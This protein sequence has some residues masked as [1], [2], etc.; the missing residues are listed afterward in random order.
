MRALAKFFASQQLILLS[1]KLDQNQ[2]LKQKLLSRNQISIRINSAT[3]TKVFK[4]GPFD[5][6]FKDVDVEIVDK[7]T[8]EKVQNLTAIL[9]YM[10]EDGQLISKNIVQ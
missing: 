4:A 8:G 1:Q 3:I 10:D 9:N 6:S 7:V 2:K 5:F